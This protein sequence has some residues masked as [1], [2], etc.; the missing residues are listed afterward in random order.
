VNFNALKH[1]IVN[2]IDD[3]PW[4]SYHQITNKDT[5]DRYR[6]LVLDELEI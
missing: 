5:I 6:D 3:Y 1:Q 4:T 2:N